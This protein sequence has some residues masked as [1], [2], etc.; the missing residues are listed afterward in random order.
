LTTIGPF[1]VTVRGPF[2]RTGHCS[3]FYNPLKLLTLLWFRV[4][5]SQFS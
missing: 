1:L 3:T 2:T 5:Q 4:L